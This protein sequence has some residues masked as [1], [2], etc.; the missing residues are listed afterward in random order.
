M[1]LK[2]L[3]EPIR[4]KD[5]IMPFGRYRGESLGDM[6]QAVPQYIQWLQDNT[7]LDFHSD[8]FREIEEMESERRGFLRENSMSIY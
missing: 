6:M 7:D 8:I 2:E 4:D 5:W 1:S 3:H